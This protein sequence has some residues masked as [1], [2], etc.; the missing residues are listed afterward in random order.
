MPAT[1]RRWCSA[2]AREQRE[3]HSGDAVPLRLRV[4]LDLL[5][6]RV[7][8]LLL[9]RGQRREPAL[10]QVRRSR[11]RHLPRPRRRRGRPARPD[12]GEDPLVHDEPG[13][14]RCSSCVPGVAGETR[15]SG[16][17]V[18]RACCLRSRC[19]SSAAAGADWY[20]LYQETHT[21]ASSTSACAWGSR[22][23]RAG[24]PAP[25]LGAPACSSRTACS[26]AS[27]DT[28][29]DR[30]RSIVAMRDSGWEQV[31]VD[32]LR[33][34][35]GTPLADVQ[36]RRRTPTNCSPSPPCGSRCRT[37]SSRPRSTWTASPASSGRLQAG[38]NVVDLHRAAHRGAR[39]RLAGGA[40]HRRGLSHGARRAAA[41]RPAGT[42]SRRRRTSTA[43]AWRR[44]PPQC[45]R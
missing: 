12:D 34:Q 35:A 36:P 20:A 2:A 15:G 41:P 1:R 26:P 39:R 32:D 11:S 14:R 17:G 31:R 16:D 45:G 5:P 38:A 21:R 33:P 23:R 13:T 42:P 9:P 27:G 3:R 4:L 44:C 28:A 30:A 8:L 10:P 40:G 43:S 19:G 18:A 25:R 7:R 6:Q 24:R 37:A 22:S 29:A